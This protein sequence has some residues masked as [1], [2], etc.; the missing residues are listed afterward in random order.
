[1][2]EDFVLGLVFF[3]PA[4]IEKRRFGRGLMTRMKRKKFKLR[5]SLMSTKTLTLFNLEVGSDR[6]LHDLLL[7]FMR[8]EFINLR[9]VAVIVAC[10]TKRASL[11]I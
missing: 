10:K 1:M 11:G 7:H 8:H 4:M 2:C 9:E 5:S 3:L 6:L